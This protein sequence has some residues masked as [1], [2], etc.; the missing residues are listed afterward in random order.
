VTVRGLRRV[1]RLLAVVAIVAATIVVPAGAAQAHALLVSSSP[2]D[3]VSL[4][5]APDQLVL[6]F[7]E[8]VTVAATTVE[9]F[10]SQGVAHPAGPATSTAGKSADAVTVPL[11]DLAP[12]R[13]L[14][15][16]RTVSSDDLHLTAG[17]LV[18]GV[19]TTVD[20]A[21][22][23]SA[24]ES[25]PPLGSLL[26]TTLRW[27]ALLAM[28]ATLGAL[29]LA[30]WLAGLLVGREAG[31]R[32]QRVSARAALVSTGAL[33]ALG[34]VAIARVS[35]ASGLSGVLGSGFLVRWLVGVGLLGTL[36]L[37]LNR[38]ADDE[39]V[40]DTRAVR[41]VTWTAMVG[42]VGAV[43]G[44]GHTTSGGLL[45]DAVAGLHLAATLL[46]VGG[47]ALL[48][49]LVVPALRRGDSAWV[50]AVVRRFTRLALPA[51]TVSVASGLLLARAL[52]PSVGALDGSGY[53]RALLVKV[54]LVA[55]ALGLGGTTAWLLGQGRA[56]QLGR[57]V[58]V[59]ETIT[60]STVLLLAAVLAGTAPPADPRWAASPEQPPTVG[61]LTENA[62]DL[63]L[64]ASLG[65]A[66]PGA[67]FATIRVLDSRR[68]ALA[69]INRV[70][71]MV[72]DATPI[73]AV[74][75][76]TPCGWPCV[77]DVDWVVSTSAITHSGAWPITVEVERTGLPTVSRTFVWNV[78]PVP[79]Q[80]QGGAALSGLLG[81]LAVASLAAGVA[82]MA[83]VVRG[84]RRP[85][86]E[87]PTAPARQDELAPF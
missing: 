33:G 7:S 37:V 26:E 46:W 17:A 23:A 54:G 21:T 41:L 29:A 63:I 31:A 40:A 25:S 30:G 1:G 32:L 47:V 87:Q 67:N 13:Y 58:L 66:V 52:V 20:R 2:A 76:G 15:R 24:G 38:P 86:T 18:F 53:G 57:R 81:W 14:V 75:Q 9:V 39:P 85:A 68:P 45:L 83:L 6:R 49:G 69:P 50:R 16:W 55:L 48:A 5:A 56:R 60:L 10:D 62:E 61:L 65:P 71:V 72:G 51:L 3:G 74:R 77:E 28:G 59:T 80:E 78:A 34:F 82:A 42:A 73:A 22:A 70:L 8:P 36:T 4:D 43:A 19:G 64:T 84:R 12:D 27:L 44:L 11:P 35:G 79:G